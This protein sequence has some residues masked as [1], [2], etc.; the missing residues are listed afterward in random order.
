MAPQIRD[1]SLTLGTSLGGK[2]MILRGSHAAR[3]KHIMGVSGAGKSKLLESIALQLLNQHVGFAL[4]DPAGDLCDHLLETLLEIG[5]FKDE[6]AYSRL[7]YL[8]FTDRERVVPFNVLAQPYEAHKIAS[9]VLESWKR[10][11]SSLAG[12]SAPAL[13]NLLLAGSLVLAENG[14]PLTHLHLLLS[15]GTYRARLLARVSDPQVVAFFDQFEEAGKRSGILS[16]STLRRIF[17]L[18]FS[19]VL[20]A[21]LG[22]LLNVN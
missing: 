13:E 9:G 6:R 20:R 1:L 2:P 15:D 11:W 18:T 7:L 5:F 16:E 22:S 8:D 17:L 19:P 3:H 4:I 12:G 14:K 21:S 10:A